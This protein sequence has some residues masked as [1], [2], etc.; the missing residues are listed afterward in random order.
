MVSTETYKG[1]HLEA[2]AELKNYYQWIISAV[3]PYLGGNGT[4]YGAGIGTVSAL[5]RPS[6]RHLELVEPSPSRGA[7]LSRRFDGDPCVTI[8]VNTLEGHL[9][10]VRDKSRD[11]LVLINVLE[12]IEDDDD[13]L[14]QFHRVLKP[15]GHLV[16]FVP[17]LSF[18]FSDLDALAKHYRRYHLRPLR[19][20]VE[21]SGLEIC[22]ARYMDV[23]GIVPWWLVNTL[24][25]KR[26]LDPRMTRAYD[27]F[28]I[29]AT[30]FLEGFFPPPIGKSIL[31]VAKRP[32]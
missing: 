24:G 18:L 28:G 27:R 11:A 22:I 19:R 13:A 29:P 3:R 23:L 10:G 12:H 2:A 32:S 16:L 20:Q 21:A 7:E 5:M 26:N 30:Q 31:L 9:P 4:E 6:M 8:V 17:A 15:G 1:Q 25:G 14:A